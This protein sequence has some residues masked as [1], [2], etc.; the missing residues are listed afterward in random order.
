MIETM[1]YGNNMIQQLK[2][3]VLKNVYQTLRA[4]AAILTVALVLLGVKRHGK[5]LAKTEQYKSNIRALKLME[6]VPPSTSDGT[7]GLLRE[8]RY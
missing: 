8:A 7:V 2:I 4:I 3:F 1:V 6:N 5:L